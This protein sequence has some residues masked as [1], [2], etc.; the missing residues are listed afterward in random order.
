METGRVCRANT[1]G[2]LLEIL[3]N[4]DLST[5]LG[6]ETV[7]FE[8]TVSAKSDYAKLTMKEQ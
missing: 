3:D 5:R 8:I 6:R 4:Q 2:D 1:V 7:L